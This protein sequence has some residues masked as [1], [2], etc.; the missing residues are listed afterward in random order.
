MVIIDQMKH[1]CKDYVKNI[2]GFTCWVE[3]K[4]IDFSLAWLLYCCF[5][6]DRIAVRRGAEIGL[7]SLRLS[8][9][10][11]GASLEDFLLAPG[12]GLALWEVLLCCYRQGQDLNSGCHGLESSA[13]PLSYPSIPEPLLCTGIIWQ[14][15]WL[16][17][18]H[19]LFILSIE[20][21][22]AGS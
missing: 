10:F 12:E 2:I 20:H 7:L 3:L 22:I 8:S 19:G 13:L 15:S 5:F 11:Q 16:P 9:V 14:Q 17:G 4:P 1:V 21:A 6:H 18:L